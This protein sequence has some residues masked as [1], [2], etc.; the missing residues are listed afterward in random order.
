MKVF[1]MV[2]R[3]LILLALLLVPAT[4]RA[5]AIDDKGAEAL[6]GVLSGLLDEQ[7]TLGGQSGVQIIKEG[8]LSVEP[9]DSYYAVTF[10]HLSIRYPDGKQ[11]E[12]GM[13]SINAV[14]HDKPGQWKMSIALPTPMLLLNDDGSEL[15]RMNIGAQQAA[16]IWLEGTHYFTKMDST[17]K[18]IALTGENGLFE[19]SIPLTRIRYNLEDDQNGMLSGPISAS[20]EG[21]RALFPQSG[22]TATIGKLQTDFTLDRYNPKAE[23]AYRRK[24]QPLLENLQSD[25]LPSSSSENK[26]G[27]DMSTLQDAM[28]EL[29]MNWGNGFSGTYSLEDLAVNMPAQGD[30]P[31]R[32]LRLKNALSGFEI[33][34]MLSD[35]AFLKVRA[36]HNGFFSNETPEKYKPFVPEN[37]NLDITARNVPLK[38]ILELA[39]TTMSAVQ[40]NPDMR[41]MAGLS[42]MMK[43]PALLS[44]AGT[45]IEFEN[46]Y[47]E[48]EAHKA[49][50]NG[51]IKADMSAISSMTAQLRATFA[52]LDALLTQA[53]ILAADPEEPAAA[54][55]AE[56]AKTLAQIKGWASVEQQAAGPLHVLNFELN[57]QGQML[58]NGRD[59]KASAPAP[60]ALP[61]STGTAQ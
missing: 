14:P 20:L 48:N 57:T 61:P 28:L 31:A 3:S 36:G 23:L 26:A 27:E 41:Q 33:G 10:P 5:Q 11:F 30:K 32:Q 47:L 18:D 13:L 53:Q 15:M 6:K 29:F 19:L 43:V 58:L 40:S 39:A 1:P 45:I 60:A 35:K 9:S 59:I 2:L 50:L 52:G 34:D 38:A 22:G 37:S 56:M 17:Y 24:I 16:G 42:L 46:N 12:F 55:F 25:D 54:Q 51:Q 7:I 49:D 21:L 4:A 44:Q 8:P